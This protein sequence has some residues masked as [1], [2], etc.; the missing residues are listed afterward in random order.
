MYKHVMVYKC[1]QFDKV[2]TLFTEIQNYIVAVL[3]NPV[4]VKMSLTQ[5][6]KFCGNQYQAVIITPIDSRVLLSS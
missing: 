3:N 1:L 4:F 6:G 5:N 2:V